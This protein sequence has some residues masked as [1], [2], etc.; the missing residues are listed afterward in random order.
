MCEQGATG[1]RSMV[2][3]NRSAMREMMI[4]FQVLIVGSWRA[5]PHMNGV[6][7]QIQP[8]RPTLSI[9]DEM[10]GKVLDQSLWLGTGDLFL[11]EVKSDISQ[12]SRRLAECRQ[13]SRSMT[14]IY[15]SIGRKF[16]YDA[17]ECEVHTYGHLRSRCLHEQQKPYL[18]DSLSNLVNSILGQ[19][20]WQA[21]TLSSH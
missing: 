16:G 9:S 20:Q 15:L 17:E 14:S 2:V 3:I 12:G 1:S 10:I 7:W 6:V 21:S 11:L 8:Q 4:A 5:Q 18:Q 19:E 13:L